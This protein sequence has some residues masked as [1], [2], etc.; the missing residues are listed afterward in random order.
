MVFLDLKD[1]KGDTWK[2]TLD[3]IWSAIVRMVSEHHETL[4][5]E[6]GEEKRRVV[7]YGSPYPASTRKAAVTLKSLCSWDL[8]NCK[9]SS[10]IN[11]VHLDDSI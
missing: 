8:R 7:D 11:D 5:E 3:L 4:K 2:E 10:K 6:L 9:K 1:C